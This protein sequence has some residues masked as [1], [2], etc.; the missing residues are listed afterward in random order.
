MGLGTSCGEGVCGQEALPD[1]EHRPSSSQ[2]QRSGDLLKVL[3]KLGRAQG[4]PEPSASQSTPLCEARPVVL[5]LEQMS[6]WGVVMRDPQVVRSSPW[7]RGT[8]VPHRDPVP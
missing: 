3:S 6:Q 7:P 4:S 2:A 1:Q 8:Y 5:E